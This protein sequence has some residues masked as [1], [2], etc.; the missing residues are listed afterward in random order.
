MG[1]MVETNGP[2]GRR[3]LDAAV[4]LVPYVDILMTLMVFLVMCAVFTQISSLTVHAKSPGVADA[5]PEAEPTQ[6]PLTIVVT[7]RGVVLELPGARIEVAR[8]TREIERAIRSLVAAPNDDTRCTLR[9]DDGV[10][11][12][13]LVE[14]ID[15]TRRV[16]ITQVSLEPT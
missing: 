13:D 15:A 9:S 4:N 5:A 10:S 16:G 1:A 6:P 3:S 12:G 11:Y 8:D 14:V 7:S 2:R